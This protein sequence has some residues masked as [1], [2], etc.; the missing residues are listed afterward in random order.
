MLSTL[1][2][3]AETEVDIKVNRMLAAVVDAAYEP[4]RPVDWDSEPMPQVACVY[5]Y[6]V[7][8]TAAA[9]HNFCRVL[10]DF[11]LPEMG[12]VSGGCCAPQVRWLTWRPTS[13]AVV[14]AVRC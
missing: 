12:P 2:T 5:Y 1:P 14:E 6:T 7:T 9:R 3:P 13:S 11:Q 10:T 4:L 8:E